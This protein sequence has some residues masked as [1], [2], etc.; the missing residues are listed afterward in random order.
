MAAQKEE[1]VR[2]KKERE[3]LKTEAKAAEMREKKKVKLEAM[4]ARKRKDGERAA[5]AAGKKAKAAK[6]EAGR[7]EASSGAALSAPGETGAWVEADAGFGDVG[8]RWSR[9]LDRIILLSVKAHGENDL[10]FRVAWDEMG[11]ASSSPFSLEEVSGRWSWL[12]TK[13]VEA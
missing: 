5:M 12:C 6:G 7:L 13:F 2:K 8:K 3:R 10:A 4:A 1:K 9:E 11:G